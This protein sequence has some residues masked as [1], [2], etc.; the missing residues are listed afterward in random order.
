MQRI[1]PTGKS[2]RTLMTFRTRMAR[3]TQCGFTLLEL[4]IVV[5][6][7][8][9][10]AAIAL[11]N[12]VQMPRRSKEAVLQTNI[13]SIQ[14]AL[15]QHNADLG[16]YPDSLEALVEEE[17]LREVPLDPM[18]DEREWG[19]DYESGE[20]ESDIAVEVDLD[21][22][23]GIIDVFSLSEDLSMNGEPYSEW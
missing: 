16:Y 7:I 10:L 19:L 15:D 1:Q 9:I 18:T 21:T 8:G 17:Y 3:R 4:I 5:S 13:R 12:L 14:K 11:P 22:G 23:Q 6:M 2:H 20:E